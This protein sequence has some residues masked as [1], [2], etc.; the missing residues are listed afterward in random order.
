MFNTYEFTFAGES[1]ISY[2]L[3]V[4]DMDSAAQEDVAF[5][6]AASIVESRTRTKIRPIHSGVSYYEDPLE[7]T[8]VF[9]S[10]KA[11][12]RYD[13]QNIAMWLTGHQEYQWLS[14]DQPDMD[15]ICYRCL[16]TS[17]K[18]ISI[19]WLPFAFQATVRC[20]CPYAYS[21]PIY[22]KWFI[23]G[24]ANKVFV[25]EGTIRDY[26]K[27]TLRIT[28][29]GSIFKIINHSDSDR[30]FS[31]ENLPAGQLVISVDNE[32]GIITE[33]SDEYNLYD[34]FNMNFFRLVPGDNLLEITGT[35]TVELECR[36]LF[37][38]AG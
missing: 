9:G 36:F 15:G 33:S 24:N 13:M 2:G 10:D 22:R 30:V 25:N 37:N 27:P 8:L 38:T 16:I 20:D 35:G 32:N 21:F 26:L 14:I 34:C 1:S 12:D 7:F 23:S 31:F 17:L 18:P 4:C 11:F 19:G 29:S 5:G 28:S 6:N 3:V